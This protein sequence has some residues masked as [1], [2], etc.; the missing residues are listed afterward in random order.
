MLAF[1]VVVALSKNTFEPLIYNIIEQ[2]KKIKRVTKFFSTSWQYFL[3][4]QQAQNCC[5]TKAKHWP[6]TMVIL[7]ICP[8]QSTRRKVV[9]IQP[10]CVIVPQFKVNQHQSTIQIAM[11]LGSQEVSSFSNWQHK[12]TLKHQTPNKKK[13]T[14]GKA[15]AL[16]FISPCHSNK[17]QDDL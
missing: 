16:Q 9:S 11:W 12:H 13:T 2:N 7:P 10:Q 1:I 17:Q 6:P 5:N 8:F 3:N 15:Y 14:R 4:I